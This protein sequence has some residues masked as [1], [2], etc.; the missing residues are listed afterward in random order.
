MA[1]EEWEELKA[2]AVER[3]ST[4]MQL[5]QLPADQGGSGTSSAGTPSG[6]LRSDKAAWSKA[7]EGVGDLRD[8]TGKALAKLEEGQ[9]G[10]DKGSGCLTAAAQKGVYDSW[11]RRVKDI[12]ELC[13]GLAGVLEKT[14]NDQLRTDEAIKTEIAKLKVH[15]EE[16]PASGDSG[17]GR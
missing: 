2:T 7:A 9:T 6:K 11:E 16:T 1:W 4:R 3:H 10:L 13:D 5:N 12:G 8:N 15:S 17:K 14:G